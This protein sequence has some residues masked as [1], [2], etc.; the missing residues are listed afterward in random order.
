M[1]CLWDGEDR[2]RFPLVI[3]Y[4]F[5]SRGTLGAGVEFPLRRSHT[6]RC[7]GARACQSV[8]SGAACS[9]RCQRPLR[10]RR[11]VVVDVFLCSKRFR[12]VCSAWFAAGRSF[13]QL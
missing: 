2:R 10:A 1:S 7:G 4:D 6:L 3:P 13:E 9:T 11:E 8:G 5:S 12:S